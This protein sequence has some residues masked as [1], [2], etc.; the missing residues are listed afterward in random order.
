MEDA[1]SCLSAR[2]F[3]QHRVES[4]RAT[5]WMDNIEAVLAIVAGALRSC[6][7]RPY[8]DSK[9]KKSRQLLATIWKAGKSGR[10]GHT[11]DALLQVWPRTDSRSRVFSKSSEGCAKQT[12]KVATASVSRRGTRGAVCEISSGQRLILQGPKDLLLKEVAQF[13]VPLRSGEAP[14]N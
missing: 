2:T 7:Q 12:R 9:D 4:G 10:D 14:F 5:E 6:F 1:E 13:H 8:R 3:A 11:N